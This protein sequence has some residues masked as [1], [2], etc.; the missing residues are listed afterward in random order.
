MSGISSINIPENVTDIEPNA[1]A[2]S[3]LTEIKVDENNKH[4]ADKDGVLFD[5]NLSTLI[6]YP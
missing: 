1:F 6:Y 2:F 5:K 4:Y 3:G